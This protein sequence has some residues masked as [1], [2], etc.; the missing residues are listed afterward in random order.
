MNRPKFKEKQDSKQDAMSGVVIVLLVFQVL[1]RPL[2][3]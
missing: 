3:R 2:Q 1:G